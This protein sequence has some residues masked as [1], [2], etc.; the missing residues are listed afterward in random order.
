[1]D[2]IMMDNT[3]STMNKARQMR[4]KQVASNAGDDAPE[5]DTGNIEQIR[6]LAQQILDILD[7]APSEEP[8]E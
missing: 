7:G 4:G 2:E 6:G 1:M 8:E 3:G 5:K